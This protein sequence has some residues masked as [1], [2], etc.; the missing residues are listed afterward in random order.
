LLT[1][2]NLSTSF[3]SFLYSTP[4]RYGNFSDIYV[5][6]KVWTYLCR[7]TYCFP[8]WSTDVRTAVNPEQWSGLWAHRQRISL[9]QSNRV[10]QTHKQTMNRCLFC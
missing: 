5:M 10:D 3:A 4:S 7:G 2:F 9:A 8:L 1:S 6:R